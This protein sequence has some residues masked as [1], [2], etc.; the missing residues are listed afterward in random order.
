MVKLAITDRA[1][2]HE[3][4][5]EFAVMPCRGDIINFTDDNLKSYERAVVMISH[6]GGGKAHGSGF[7]EA[8]LIVDA[9]S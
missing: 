5:A 9:I 2:G 7:Y 3:R 6:N 4:Y 8:H 1:S